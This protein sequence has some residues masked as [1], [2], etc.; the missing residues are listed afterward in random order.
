MWRGF[1]PP[2]PPP[3][4]LLLLL[5]LPPLALTAKVPA[6]RIWTLSWSGHQM[7]MLDAVP[8]S[9]RTECAVRCARRPG[10]AATAY[11][12]SSSPLTCLLLACNNGFNPF[13]GNCY[14]IFTNPLSW[15]DARAGCLSLNTQLVSI[16]SEM[17]NL[18]VDFLADASGAGRIHIGLFLGSN[19]HEWADGSPVDFIKWADGEGQ[20]TSDASN[21]FLPISASMLSAE[22]SS[23][24]DNGQSDL[25]RCVCKREKVLH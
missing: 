16:H 15:S 5:L 14:A 2:S 13:D 11:N 23:W 12:P 3:P 10:C 22:G 18:F 17:E 20:A 21:G 24:A 9:S 25:Y 7:T 19:G 6:G 4:L 8:S 1:L